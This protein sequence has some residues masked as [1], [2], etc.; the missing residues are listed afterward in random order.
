MPDQSV[1]RTHF[2]RPVNDVPCGIFDVDMYPGMRIQEL[3]FRNLSFECDVLVGIVF[4]RE[5]MMR[6]GRSRGEKQNRNH[7]RKYRLDLLGVTTVDQLHGAKFKAPK[8][9]ALSQISLILG[10]VR[11]EWQYVVVRTNY[12]LELTPHTVR[13]V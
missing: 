7:T 6:Q 12:P 1:R 2:D 10:R 3:D 8:K 13:L 4:R 9:T 11:L 5:R